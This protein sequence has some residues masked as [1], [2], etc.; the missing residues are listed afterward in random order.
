MEPG[1]YVHMQGI[2]TS[3]K[4]VDQER[5]TLGIVVDLLDSSKTTHISMISSMTQST[6]CKESNILADLI[7]HVYEEGER[8][9]QYEDC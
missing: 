3:E 5:V 1:V 4:W 7:F 6:S 2:H 8:T 9:H